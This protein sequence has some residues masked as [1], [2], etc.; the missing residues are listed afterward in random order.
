MVLLGLMVDVLNHFDVNFMIPVS[1]CDENMKRAHKR[2]AINTE[3]FWFNINCFTE[4]MH[5]SDL[6]KN[7]FLRS[8]TDSKL[9]QPDYQEL[10]LAE[11]FGGKDQFPGMFE[12]IRKFMVIRSYSEN[13]TREF[14][15]ILDF[16]LARCLGEVPTGAAFIRHYI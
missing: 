14:E 1:M 12:I 15:H 13:Q 8:R 5:E 11:I 9:K 16:V 7:N 2:D 10:S 4:E 6:V 3:K